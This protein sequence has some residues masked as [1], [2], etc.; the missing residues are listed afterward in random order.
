[1]RYSGEHQR[2]DVRPS[3]DDTTTKMEELWDQIKLD[4]LPETLLWFALLSRFVIRDVRVA[5]RAPR[6]G[7]VLRDREWLRARARP[8]RDLR[9]DE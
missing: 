8:R 4:D 3:D 1:M 5:R 2:G 6:G 9:V 7:P